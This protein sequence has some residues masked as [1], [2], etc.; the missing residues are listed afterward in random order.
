MSG[1]RFAL[2]ILSDS[3]SKNPQDDR[4]KP[5]VDEILTSNGFVLSKYYIIP[6][7]RLILKDKLLELSR[8]DGIDAI[9]TSGGTGL[10]ERDITPDVTKEVLDYEIPAIPQA[11][12]FNALKK[13]KRAMLSRMVAGVKNNKLIIN[14]P[15]SPKAVREDLEYIVDVLE[16]A[17]DKLKGD[18]TPCGEN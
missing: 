5:I 11:I 17:L 10:F 12:L 16:H 13:T 6:D 18:T 4:V 15:G 9:I 8:D 1:Y 7:E 3:K 14:L 2:L